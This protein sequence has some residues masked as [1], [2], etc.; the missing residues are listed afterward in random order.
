MEITGRQSG[1]R[2]WR[3]S[4]HSLARVCVFTCK[5]ETKCAS[6]G[7]ERPSDGLSFTERTSVYV[8]VRAIDDTTA[9]HFRY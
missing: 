7:Y 6:L 8:D 1:L 4:I 5:T 2:K 9:G 3:V